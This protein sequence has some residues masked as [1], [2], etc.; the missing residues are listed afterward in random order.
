MGKNISSDITKFGDSKK[1]SMRFAPGVPRDSAQAEEDIVLIQ[2]ISDPTRIHI[3]KT[4]SEHESLCGKDI[5]AHFSITQPTLSHH[6]NMLC[7]S[8]LVDSVKD[9]KYVQYHIRQDGIERVIAFFESLAGDKSNKADAADIAGSRTVSAQPS[10]K[11]PSLKKTPM[12][13]TPKTVIQSPDIPD[14]TIIENKKI[15]KKDKDKD[16]KKEKKKRKKN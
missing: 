5:L 4:L 11:G 12:L 10:V 3:L 6:M 1:P 9:G 14:E 16:G 15:K 13:P 2:V 8:G 7:N